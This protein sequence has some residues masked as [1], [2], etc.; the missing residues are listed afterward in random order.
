M[1]LRE[2]GESWKKVGARFSN[3]LISIELFKIVLK[4][5]VILVK[6]RSFLILS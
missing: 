5:V 4:Q 6:T 1:E 3:T 2:G